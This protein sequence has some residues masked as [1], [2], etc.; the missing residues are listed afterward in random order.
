VTE[1]DRPALEAY[2]AAHSDICMLMR[3]NLRV[4]GLT[5]RAPDGERLQAQY[6][7]ARRG[8]AVIGAAAHYWNGILQV[9]ADAHAGELAVAAARNSG[10]QIAGLLGELAQVG[11]ARR[12]LG[13][14]AAAATMDSEETLMAL[15]LDRLAV[16]PALR[17]GVVIGRRAEPHDRELLIAWRTA[18]GLET[19]LQQTAAEA[20]ERATAAVDAT[21]AE[22]DRR[23]WVL[24]HDGAP[25]ATCAHNAVLPDAVQ[26]G[27]VFTPPALRGRGHARAVV[28]ASLIDARATGATR[29]TLFTPRADAVA[30][31]RAV[32]FAPI[33][34]Y[35]IVLFAR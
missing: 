30:A 25:V 13:L 16:P 9:Q 34:R 14:D 28:A 17:D 4:A 10:R 2:L 31:Y 7:L 27:G 29:A 6:L 11:A 32:G 21:L 22:A 24:E 19:E 20:E 15:A 8:G 5:W 12:A 35:A 23:I 18:Y 1:A 26:I 3:S 33:G